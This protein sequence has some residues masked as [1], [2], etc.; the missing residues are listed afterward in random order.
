MEKR[1]KIKT[2]CMIFLSIGLLCLVILIVRINN[3][4][5]KLSE[6]FKSIDYS[7][8][9]EFR[10]IGQKIF[11]TTRQW[12][13]GGQH[14]QTVISDVDHKNNDI[15]IDEEK[16]IIFN[17]QCGL[18][19]KKQEPDS[20]FIFMSSHSYSE[21]EEI[22]RKIGDVNVKIYRLTVQIYNEKKDNYKSLGWSLISCSDGI[23]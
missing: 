11:I 12:G 16:E 6:D 8:A 3:D 7:T 5:S 1:N 13:L 19:Y 22:N 18:Y 4:F 15:L 20:L 23:E 9:I 2:G 10:D 17:G 14:S 21:E